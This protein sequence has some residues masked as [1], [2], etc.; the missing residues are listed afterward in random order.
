MGGKNS[1]TATVAKKDFASKEIPVFMDSAND[2]DL[3]EIKEIY[4]AWEGPKADLLSYCNEKGS[5]AL[6]L[7][8][9]NGHDDIVEFIVESIVQDCS[10][11]THELLN[12]KNHI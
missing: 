8:A 1:K 11:M 9:N 6:H 7:A 12:K 5:T 4:N 2:G 10:D 3:D